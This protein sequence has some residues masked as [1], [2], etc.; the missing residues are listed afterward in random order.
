M[1]PV[2]YESEQSRGGHFAAWECPDAIAGDLR[3][4]FGK[5]GV[6]AGIVKGSSGFDD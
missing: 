2:V 4:M 5:G 3:K 1:G 6:C